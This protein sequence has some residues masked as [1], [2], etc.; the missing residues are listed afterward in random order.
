MAT[1]GEN[2]KYFRKQKKMTQK[3][4]ATLV[5]V[6]EV[7]IRSYELGKYNPKINILTRLSIAFDCKV[8][9]LMDEEKKKYYRMFDESKINVTHS[10]S[11]DRKRELLFTELFKTL[12]YQIQKSDNQE[13]IITDD[14]GVS[15]SVSK[16][17]FAEIINRCNKDIKYNLDKFLK[18]SRIIK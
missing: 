7:T 9:D 3:E 5:G 13:L 6:N 16:N 14:Q 2:I 12:N 15:F 1:I 4:L 8:T 17:T 18:D 10:I 11:T